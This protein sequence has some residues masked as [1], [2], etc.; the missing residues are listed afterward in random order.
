MAAGTY[1]ARATGYYSWRGYAACLPLRGCIFP[2]WVMEL[3]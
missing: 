2:G 1:G 3:A